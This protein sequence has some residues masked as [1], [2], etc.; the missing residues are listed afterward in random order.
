MDPS[1]WELYESGSEDDE[2]GVIVRMAPGVEPPPL[3]RIVSRFGDVYTARLRRGDIV[4][5]RQ[6]PGVV[7]VKA[8][9]PVTLPSPVESIARVHADAE[10]DPGTEEGRSPRQLLTRPSVPE[11]G[12]GVVVGICDWGFDFTHRNFRNADG[13]TRLLCL[14][15]QRGV[16][17]PL[18]PAPYGYGRLLTRPA[19]DAAL[20]T[21]DPCGTLGYHPASGDPTNTGSHGTHVADILAGNRREPGSE[22]GLASGADLVFVHLATPRLGELANLGDS[23]GLLEGLDFCR[24]QA[25]GRPCVLHLSAGK[26]GGEKRGQSP[27]ERA[28]DAMLIEPGIVLVQSVGNYASTAMHTHARLGPDQRYVINWIIPENDRTPNEL[29]IWYSGEDVFD[30][31]LIAPGGR[32]FTLPLDQRM[33]LGDDFSAWGNFYHRLHEPNSGLN[34]IVVFLYPAAPSGMWRVS[35]HGREIVDGRLHAWIERDA[36]GRFQSRFLKS[37]ASSRYTTNT[38]CNCYR[39]I[40]VG[41][42]DGTRPDRPPTRFSSR[43]PTADGRQKPEL[44]APGYMIR[45]AR[46]MPRNGWRDGQSRL[47]VKSGTSMAAPWVSGTVALMFQAAGRP[48][49]IH[50]I[51][52]ALIGSADPHPGPK[53]LSSTR[54]GYGYLNVDGAVAAARLLRDGAQSRAT[55]PEAA[56]TVDVGWA[57]VWVEDA[58]ISDETD[59]A[60]VTEDLSPIVEDVVTLPVAH[61]EIA[62]PVNVHECNCGGKASG[63]VGRTSPKP[64]G[65][66]GSGQVDRTLADPEVGGPLADPEVGRTLSGP[67]ETDDES[68]DEFE[69]FDAFESPEETLTTP[70]GWEDV[71]DA[72]E[73]LNETVSEDLG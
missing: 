7:S 49:S 37:Q 50:E 65:E 66:G 17:D 48:L 5:V 32:E 15:D 39:A 51:R 4:A 6:S 41:A 45:A 29:E 42:Y 58:A 71:E 24:R 25:A 43:G 9:T 2:V 36:G 26:T 22:V 64:V 62:A 27:I 19:I 16:G 31:T 70:F 60:P 44:A 12:S 21:S 54:L 34:H 47:C 63:P 46:S 67:A 1:L 35:L 14:W 13:T 55:P 53:G 72:L 8:S 30:V 59:L 57:P 68:D 73:V 3:V 18:A 56:E 61:T 20:K 28:V 38:I 52:R 69:G 40:A 11:D 10:D 23:V 33:R